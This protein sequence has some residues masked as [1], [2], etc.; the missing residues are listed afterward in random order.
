[1]GIYSTWA[2]WNVQ[3]LNMREPSTIPL[4]RRASPLTLLTR[5]L[6]VPDQNIAII[7]LSNVKLGTNALDVTQQMSALWR[8]NWQITTSSTKAKSIYFTWPDHRDQNER[9]QPMSYAHSNACDTWTL[10][11]VEERHT[12]HHHRAI[13]K[14][15]WDHFIHNKEIHAKAR[16]RAEASQ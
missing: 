14:S 13:M 9:L 11:Q 3:Y 1:M 8:R 4:K 10:Y 15:K 6:R 7:Q 12:I 2:G 5:Q 16:H